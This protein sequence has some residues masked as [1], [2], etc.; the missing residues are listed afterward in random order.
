MLRAPAARAGHLL[1][2]HQQTTQKAFPPFCPGNISLCHWHTLMLSRCI[3]AAP[4]STC[5]PAGFNRQ[6]GMSDQLFAL[7]D[8]ALLTV[9]GQV[10]F[11]PLLVLAARICPEVRQAL[12][13]AGR[14][15]EM[16][17]YGTW[18]VGWAG[19][20][21]WAGAGCSWSPLPCRL[22]CPG[23]ARSAHLRPPPLPPPLRALRPPCLPP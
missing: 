14:C 20:L 5:P 4:P 16:G 15:W 3:R 7:A 6:L 19:W 10:A 18:L 9:L 8:T 2:L 1:F 13:I 21:Q 23:S 11:M 12:C 17:V 22:C